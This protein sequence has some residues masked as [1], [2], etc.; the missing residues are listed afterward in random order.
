MVPLL[1][2]GIGMPL[3]AA[4]LLPLAVGAADEWHQL[5]LPGRDGS[6]DDWL[7]DA[8]GIGLAGL[9]LWWIEKTQTGAPNR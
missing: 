9:A 5:Y 4:L 7:A 2:W 8:V 1:R 6:V 3:L